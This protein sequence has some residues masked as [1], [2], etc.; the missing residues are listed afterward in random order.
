MRG[1]DVAQRES[2]GVVLPDASVGHWWSVRGG[3]VGRWAEGQVVRPDLWQVGHCL[4]WL[5]L[6]FD[7]ALNETGGEQQDAPGFS[8]P[9]PDAV[10]HAL[11]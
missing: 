11:L 7:L 6:H 5:D 10:V 9:V 3:G 1:R 4:L 2:D 8:C